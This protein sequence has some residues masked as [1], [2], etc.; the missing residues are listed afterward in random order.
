MDGALQGKV[1]RTYKKTDA[2]TGWSA[3]WAE[4]KKGFRL[5]TGFQRNGLKRLEFRPLALALPKYTRMRKLYPDLCTLVN[6][7]TNHTESASSAQD[8][9]KFTHDYPLS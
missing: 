2:F 5:T 9:H 6:A 3:A 8:A 7:Y 1:A 4:G